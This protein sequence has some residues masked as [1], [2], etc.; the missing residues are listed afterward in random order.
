MAF[1]FILQSVLKQNKNTPLCA[2][3]KVLKVSVIFQIASF[4]HPFTQSCVLLLVG[5]G[6]E[7]RPQ[8]SHL[9]N[10]GMTGVALCLNHI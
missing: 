6:F 10:A 3:E 4:P 8:V 5:E 9:T 2:Q 7:T 1:H